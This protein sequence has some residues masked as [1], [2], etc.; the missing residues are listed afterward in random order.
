MDEM[1]LVNVNIEDHK[2]PEFERLQDDA[3]ALC[4]ALVEDTQRQCAAHSEPPPTAVL[5]I[6]DDAFKI[7]R[8]RE[9]PTSV[10][11]A[12]GQK[13][14]KEWGAKAGA[15][16][17]FGG[18]ADKANGEPCDDTASPVI[19]VYVETAKGEHAIDFHRPV[20][21]KGRI[22]RFVALWRNTGEDAKRA[23]P[24]AFFGQEE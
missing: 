6:K 16:I 1:K 13:L 22:A 12:L 20:A 7:F 11:A 23:A 10:I 14:A 17:C 2:A 21:H 5:L 19:V 3:A 4:A 24:F 18:I 8:T 15:M 9:L